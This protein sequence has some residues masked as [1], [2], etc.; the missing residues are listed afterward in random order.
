MQI[1]LEKS[2]FFSIL[3]I[4]SQ[5]GKVRFEETTPF[6]C[7]FSFDVKSINNENNHC[8]ALHSTVP[9]SKPIIIKRI[10]PIVNFLTLYLEQK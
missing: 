4:F 9:V 3:G 1:F 10:E 5:F 7:D 2:S 8:Q 6:S